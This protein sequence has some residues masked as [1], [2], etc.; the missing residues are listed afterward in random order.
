MLVKKPGVGDQGRTGRKENERIHSKGTKE[1]TGT[2][3]R[4]GNQDH[5][6]RRGQKVA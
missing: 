6:G 1:W 2:A 3:G 4:T 5:E